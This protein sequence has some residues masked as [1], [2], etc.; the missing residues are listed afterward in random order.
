M[1]VTVEGH[2]KTSYLQMIS[3][4]TAVSLYFMLQNGKQY[5]SSAML[6]IILILI[7][8]LIIIII[9]ILIIIIYYFF[10][11]RKEREKRRR[12]NKR[13]TLGFLTDKSTHV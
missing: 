3:L 6:L 7:L 13:D 2:S 12:T 1:G 10:L 11:K 8:I 4:A 9:I 5:T